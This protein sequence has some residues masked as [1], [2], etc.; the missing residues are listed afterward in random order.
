MLIFASGVCT[1][2]VEIKHVLL[3]VAAL[4][5]GAHQTRSKGIFQ[6]AT[7]LL[8][9]WLQANVLGMPRVRKAVLRVSNCRSLILIFFAC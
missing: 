1:S 6:H 7:N 2:G 9:H 3:A 8:T 4:E 5:H